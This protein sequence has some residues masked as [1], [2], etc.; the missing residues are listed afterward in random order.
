MPPPSSR[1]VYLE[2]FS[3]SYTDL[4]DGNRRTMLRRIADIVKTL[5][6]LFRCT[7]L[8]VA[9]MDFEIAHLCP[10]VGIPAITMASG[11][12]HRSSLP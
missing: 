6:L 10:E 4:L 8:G 11:R 5:F 12:L 2:Y 3:D 9:D 1:S 7:H